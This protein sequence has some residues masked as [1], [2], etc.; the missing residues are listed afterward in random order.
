MKTR[1]EINVAIAKNQVMYAVAKGQF[2]T[3]IQLKNEGIHESM[4]EWKTKPSYIKK[5]TNKFNGWMKNIKHSHRESY[6][7]QITAQLHES[8]QPIYSTEE[9]GIS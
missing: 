9:G 6:T 2:Y 3:P 8:Y 7:K 5:L 1:G 4:I